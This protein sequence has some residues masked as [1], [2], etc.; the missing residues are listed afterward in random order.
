MFCV[1]NRPKLHNCCLFFV[2]V[3]SVLNGDIFRRGKGK[4]D[5][6]AKR[7]VGCPSGAHFLVPSFKRPPPITFPEHVRAELCFL[8]LVWLG[9][10]PIGINLGT[11]CGWIVPLVLAKTRPLLWWVRVAWK[12]HWTLRSAPEPVPWP[13]C[14][15]LWFGCNSD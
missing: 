14:S 5:C 9:S 12:M 8:V 11:L 15:M 1:V 6:F 10:V 2:M 3:L 13:P 7:I 4:K